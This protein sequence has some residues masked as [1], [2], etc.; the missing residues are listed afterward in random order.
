[1]PNRQRVSNSKQHTSHSLNSSFQTQNSHPISISILHRSHSQTQPAYI[2]HATA[3]LH[4]CNGF[5][6]RPTTSPRTAAHAR[7]C[8]GS[9][10][11]QPP[12][13]TPRGTPLPLPRTHPGR[14]AAQHRLDPAATIG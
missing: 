3:M 13:T 10:S 5:G 11:A 2:L 14:V 4:I 6:D 1:M 7:Q 9:S 8:R 12:R